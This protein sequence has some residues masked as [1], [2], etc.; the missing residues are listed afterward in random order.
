MQLC[1]TIQAAHGRAFLVGGCVRDQLRQVPNLDYDLEVYGLE[2]SRL[3]TLLEAQG[4]VNAVG[5]AFTVYKVKLGELTIDVSIP[6][7]ESKVGRGHRGFE[8][9]GDPW[10]RYE[11]AARRRDFTINAV[12][13]DPLSDEVVDPFHGREDIAKRLI[14]AVDPDTFV[15]DSLRVLRAMQFAARFEFAIDP[16]TVELCRGID[17][18]DLPAERIWAEVEKWLLQSNKPSVGF[19]AAIQL[20]MTEKLWPEIHAL[21]GC[22]QE[23]EWH[24]EGDVDIHTAMVIDEARKLIDDLPR[25]KKLAVMLGALAHDFG[26][27]A[28]TKNEDG[29][30]RSKGHEDAGVAP[31]EA[32]LDRLKLNTIDGYDVRQQVIALVAAHLVPG[33]FYKSFQKGEKVSDGA[34]RRLAQ[35]V[36]PDLLYRV[37]RADCLGRTGDFKPDAME[38]FIARARE[39][40]VVEKAPPPIL[41]GRHVLSL[42]LK[43]GPQVGQITKAVYELQLDGQVV[44]LDEAIA[45]AQGLIE[46]EMR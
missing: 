10:M 26:K 20:G 30:I 21:I 2:P 45:A 7:R 39:L 40:S 25:P 19:W 34:F 37:A 27:P 18:S 15:E 8:V 22:P 46:G 3:R 31:T 14:R 4:K 9:T 41:L 17:L 23:Y 12:M 43:P 33:H 29:R 38:W 42:G 32:F 1:R 5:E 36:E 6:R 28:T 11:D 13:Y 24:P 16:A 44:T 35:R